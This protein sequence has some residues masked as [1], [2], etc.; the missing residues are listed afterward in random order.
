MEEGDIIAFDIPA[1]SIELKVDED[2]LAKRRLAMES[3]EPGQVYQP[4]APRRRR[5]SKALRAYAVFASSADK[6]GVRD[7][8]KVNRHQNDR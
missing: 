7:L 6:G 4:L 5:V 2:T 1:R 3:R 8:D